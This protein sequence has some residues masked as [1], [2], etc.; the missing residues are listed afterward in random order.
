[1]IKFKDWKDIPESW[2]YGHFRKK[3]V[4]VFV[5]IAREECF[6]E[7]LEGTHKANKGDLIIQGIHN[8]IYPCKPDIFRKT[9]EEDK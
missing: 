4:K 8:E 9:Y 2:N 5:F 3:P 7:T 1:M 6:I